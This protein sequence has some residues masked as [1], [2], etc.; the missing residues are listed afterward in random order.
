MVF[1]P[2]T[3]GKV[4]VVD[5]E[6]AMLAQ[7]TWGVA[8]HKR[9]N[10]MYATRSVKT[11]EGLRR[12]CYMHREILGVK[13][14]K[15][16]VDHIDGD[17]LNNRRCNLR[18]VTWSENL[19]NRS[20]PQRNNCSG[21]LGVCWNKKDKKWVAQIKANGKIKYLG[22]FKTAEEA[23]EARLAAEKELWG[24]TPRRAHAHNSS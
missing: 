6:D 15:V 16:A 3:Q 18:V 21:Y 17:G 7:Y 10:A 9:C 20:G 13:N 14:P 8:I 1:I 19:R 24:I 11:S 12:L 23:N 4:T 5:D 2:L 22:S